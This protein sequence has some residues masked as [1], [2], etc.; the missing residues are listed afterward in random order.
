MHLGIPRKELLPFSLLRNPI[1]CKLNQ[2]SPPVMNLNSKT[3]KH[4][5]IVEVCSVIKSEVGQNNGERLTYL[6][7]MSFILIFRSAENPVIC[8]FFSSGIRGIFKS[9]YEVARL[10]KGRSKKRKMLTWTKI[11]GVADSP[12]SLRMN[13]HSCFE[14]AWT[15]DTN[16][17]VALSKTLLSFRCQSRSCGNRSGMSSSS[18][19]S[20]GCSVA[21]NETNN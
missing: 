6:Y 16:A 17:L 21:W 7:L 9:P 19:A 4:C 14:Y 15:K 1:K 5:V 20:K 12:L 13:L 2:K 11:S 10:P 8:R 3:D 18:G